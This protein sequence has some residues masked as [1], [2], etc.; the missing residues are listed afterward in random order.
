MSVPQPEQSEQEEQVVEIL[1]CPNPLEKEKFQKLDN[2]E[3]M[4]NLLSIMN[5]FCEKVA[6]IN[7][8]IHDETQGLATRVATVQIQADESTT[9]L[10]QEKKLMYS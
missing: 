8:T 10:A 3:K 9:T 2:K 7:N 5:N 1:K 6:E 4:G